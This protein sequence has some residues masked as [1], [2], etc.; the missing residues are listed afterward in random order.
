MR[1]SEKTG[2]DGEFFAAQHLENKG[3]KILDRNYRIRQGEIDIIAQKENYIVFAEVKTRVSCNFAQ[4][5][6]FVTSAKQQKI[7]L[8]ASSWLSEN[9]TNFQPRFDV[10]EVYWRKNESRPYQ[11]LCIENAF[12]A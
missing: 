2:K 11:I 3:Y 5:R 9:P 4:A 1:T 12:E 6:E 8:T 10:I 7:L